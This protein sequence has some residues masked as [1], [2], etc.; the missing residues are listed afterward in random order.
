MTNAGST[1][2]PVR[3]KSPFGKSNI[4]RTESGNIVHGAFTPVLAK[5]SKSFS[6]VDCIS[7]GVD[8]TQPKIP[9]TAI[10]ATVCWNRACEDSFRS[11]HGYLGNPIAL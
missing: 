5:H 3:R 2:S 6:L 8:H 9:P 1:K 4:H 7:V 11:R 10:W